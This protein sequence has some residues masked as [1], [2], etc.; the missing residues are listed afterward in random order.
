MND[1]FCVFQMLFVSILFG[2]GSMFN[3]RVFKVVYL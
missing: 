2:V 3:A 1:S